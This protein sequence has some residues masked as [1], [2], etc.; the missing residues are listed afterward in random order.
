MAARAAVN[1]NKNGKPT[2]MA[3]GKYD[4]YLYPSVPVSNWYFESANPPN[5]TLFPLSVFFDPCSTWFSFFS[6][7]NHVAALWRTVIISVII[8]FKR[9]RCFSSNNRVQQREKQWTIGRNG[10]WIS[11]NMLG[12][13]NSITSIDEANAYTAGPRNGLK[14]L[15]SEYE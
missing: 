3:G 14:A 11:I 9:K 5:T 4:A 1:I 12:S 6:F 15:Q 2:I 10:S 8:M 13:K 7:V